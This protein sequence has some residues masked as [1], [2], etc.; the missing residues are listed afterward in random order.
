MKTL[1]VNG[2]SWTAGG[3]LDVPDTEEVITHLHENIVWSAHVK[4]M[5]NFN[6]CINLAEGCASNQR[7]CRTTFEWISQQSE[8]VLE[9]TTVIIQW[10][11]EDRFEYYIPTNEERNDFQKRYQLSPATPDDVN[12]NLA[13]PYSLIKNLDRWAKVNPHTLMS[14]LENHHKE[15][16]KEDA[17]QRYKTY[18]AQEGMYNWLFH[19]GF[20]YDFLTSKGIECYFWYFSQYCRAM[21]QHIQDYI[22]NHFPMLEDDRCHMWEYERIGNGDSHPN[23]TGHHQIATQI[24]EA[25]AKKK[26]ILRRP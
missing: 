15:Y 21:P 17:L 22:H 7:I 3:G 19:M 24:V 14:P 16:V 18:T 20:L 12:A 25:I 8:S 23:E 4:E 1:F 5:M 6:R 2:C 9:N 26:T 11:D 10:S 13:S